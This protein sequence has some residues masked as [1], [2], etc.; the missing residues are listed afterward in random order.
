MSSRTTT[1]EPISTKKPRLH[2]TLS[3]VYFSPIEK[4]MMQ[5][6]R[7]G[8]PHTIYELHRCIQDEYGRIDNVK[9]HV[10]RLRKK[11]Q[12]LGHDI[13]CVWYKMMF[14]YQQVIL[15]ENNGKYESRTKTRRTES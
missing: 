1:P 4:R 9:M 12:P 10:T 5:V 15:L 13:L 7:D 3:K 11:I 8:R 14:R 2:R 6:F